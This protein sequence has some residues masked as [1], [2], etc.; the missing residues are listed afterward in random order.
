MV[1]AD[2]SGRPTLARSSFYRAVGSPPSSFRIG[3]IAMRSVDTGNIVGSQVD[4]GLSSGRARKGIRRNAT[5][6]LLRP[7]MAGR[8]ELGIVRRIV[9]SEA[10][11]CQQDCVL[12]A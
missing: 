5:T 8:D 6:S 9:R 11:Y 10:R 2:P 12:T 1:T 4:T 7:S 3:K